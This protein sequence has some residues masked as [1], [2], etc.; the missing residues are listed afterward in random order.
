MKLSFNIPSILSLAIIALFSFTVANA[1]TFSCPQNL[2]FE[3]GNLSNWQFFT[4]NCCPVN[5]TTGGPPVAGR[6]TLTTGTAVDPYGGFPIVPPGGGSF[7]LKL[8]N[9]NV[10][11]EAERARYYVRVP[12]GPQSIYTLLYR[13]AVVFQD[14]SHPTNEQPRF[15]VNVFDSATGQPLPCNQFTFVASSSLP[16]FKSAGG[17]VW[18]K[19]W[20]TSSIDLSAMAG[21]TVAVDFTASDCGY[22]GHFGYAYID[23][24]CGLFQVYNLHCS[25]KSTITLSAPPGFQNYEWYDSTTFTLLGTGQTLTQPTPTARKTFAV[26][27]TPYTG[28]GCPDTVYTVFTISD[29][30]VETSKDTSICRGDSIILDSWTNSNSAPYT[31]QWTPSAGLSCN[32]CVNPIASPLNTTKYYLT[33]I[34]SNGCSNIDSVTVFVDDKVIADIFIPKDTFCAYEQINMQNNGNSPISSDYAWNLN[35]DD[36]TITSGQGSPSIIGWWSLEGLKRI[37]LTITTGKNCV[38]HDSAKVYIKA[39]PFAQFE[40]KSD[41]CLNEIAEIIPYKQD[42]YYYWTI[43]DNKIEDTLFRDVYKLSWNTLGIKKISLFLKKENGCISSYDTSVEIHDFPPAEIK[44]SDESEICLGHNVDL[45]TPKGDRFIYEWTPP[46]LFTGNNSDRVT[47]KIE[48]TA[49]LRLKVTS[50]WG[51][52]SY[53]SLYVEAKPCCEILIPNAFTPNN[54]GTNDLFKPIGLNYHKVIRFM[55]SNRWGQVIFDTENSNTGWDG[56]FKGTA[57]DPGTYNYYIKYLCN[58]K[59]TIER[60]GNIILLK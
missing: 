10:G 29:M 40:I 44:V 21:K 24:S 57:Q 9:S 30:I 7:A 25:S 38:T 20:S 11:A 43:D 17:G 49:Q 3:S 16:G 8:G 35:L 31:Y 22:G 13:Y 60:K 46:L 32:N 50:Q 37:E 56:K 28:F 59:E 23:V 1:Q 4:G 58:D 33:M 14:P 54:D 41:I 6:H 2:D 53:D 48:R 51:C 45:S 5:T 27:L 18:Y 47:A 39:A 34:D 26:I 12:S 42:A 15:E 36:G 52:S 55:V 19:D